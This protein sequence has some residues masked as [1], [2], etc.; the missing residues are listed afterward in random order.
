MSN[1]PQLNPDLLKLLRCPVA[2][3][4]G[5][6]DDPGKL[7]IE[8]GG[9]WLVCEENGYKYPV[10]SGIPHMIAEEGA[11]WRDIAIADLP[12]PPPEEE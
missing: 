11:R 9:W 8:H 4:E 1:P 5:K 3:R 10:R 2:V 7:S 12:V 6:G